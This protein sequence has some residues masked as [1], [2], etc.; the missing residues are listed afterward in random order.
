[1]PTN[2]LAG[3]TSPYLLQHAHNPVEW[4]PWGAEALERARAEDR[5]IF[6]SIG[7]AACH[8][9]HVMERESFEDPVTAAYLNANFVSIKVDREE[10]PDLDAIYMQAVQA[11]TGSGGWPMSVF[12][13][14]DGKPFYGGTYFPNT[15]RHGLPSFRDVLEGVDHGWRER[16]GDVE[17]AGVAIV[18]R[19][20]ATVRLGEGADSADA[21]LL[22]AAVASLEAAFDAR[23]GGW[24]TPMKFPQPMAIEFLLR[25]AAA[26]DARALPL[27]RRTLDAMAAGGIH[28]QLGGGFSRYA[29]EPTWLVPHFEKML[30][31]NAQLAR[32]YLHAWQLSRD[33]RYLAVAR[34]TLDFVAREMTLADG[35]FAASLDAD[36]EGEEGATYTW[37]VREVRDAL[38]SAGLGADVELF[39]A[40]FD[41]TPGGNWEGRT[42][43]R[44]V[45]T[46][47]EL[48]A[49]AGRAEAEVRE[50]LDG[51]R[52][53][54]R[55]FRDRR[56]QPARDG[57]A[58]A[59]WN[60]LMLAA[61]ADVAAVLERLPDTTLAEAGRRYRDIAERAGERLLAVLLDQN[62]RLRR[63]WKDGQARHA[64]T[65]EDHACLADG[66]LA[67]HEATANERWF[68]AARALAD[69]ILAHFGDPAGG[70]FDTADDAERLVARPRSLEDNALPSGNAMAALVLQRLA[71]LTGEGAYA[72]AA[73][74]AM[75]L[76][77]TAPA[78]YPTAFAQWLVALDWRA[79]PVDEIALVGAPDDPRVGRLLDVARAG[80]R[81]RQVIA[82]APDPA[83][84]AVP[85]LQARFAIRG[86]PTA[87]VCRG[88]ACR[89]PVTEPEAL[90]ALLVG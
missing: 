13:T 89:Q 71:A 9:C 20:A 82:V 43:L 35:V 36:T 38:E 32:V 90:A 28:D 42:I 15:R 14:P 51:A 69:T 84:S 45:A 8:W 21:D 16:R 80:Y 72:D 66:L 73:E 57:K 24:G 11:L 67:L 61:F 41:V 19:L 60:G 39:A 2:R 29:T 81:P 68:T 27:V 86:L 10:R 78:R 52:A 50:R 5:P 88:F 46:N 62:G 17:R 44:R 48:A 4:H 6:L 54:L 74:G 31:D 26:G 70:F 40:A 65:L 76:V 37:T 87:F 77:G 49:R 79:G 53:A 59:G 30:S 34:S 63:S 58:L 64:G 18:A 25:R 3:E 47:T 83:S 75:G 1:M 85:L 56:P 12:L 23:N 7:Y 33:T 55:A 22:D